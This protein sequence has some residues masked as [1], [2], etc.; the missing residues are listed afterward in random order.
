MSSSCAAAVELLKGRT[1]NDQ[2]SINTY[3]NDTVSILYPPALLSTFNP[4]IVAQYSL[5]K[6]VNT[7]A[8][9]SYTPMQSMA[10]KGVCLTPGPYYTLSTAYNEQVGSDCVNFGQDLNYAA[11]T[12]K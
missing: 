6:P 3:K 10:S 4:A 8:M 5:P 2:K 1:S 9:Y 12:K 11:C 7:A